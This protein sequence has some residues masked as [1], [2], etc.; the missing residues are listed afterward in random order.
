MKRVFWGFAAVFVAIGLI[1]LMAYR[2]GRLEERK[3]VLQQAPA[4]FN[5]GLVSPS[6][7]SVQ[8][9]ARSSLR[10]NSNSAPQPGTLKKRPWDVQWVA[11]LKQARIGD[12]LRFELV[13]G[14]YALGTIRQLRR[15]GDA[16][17]YVSGEVQ[18]PES[19]RFFFQKQ[20][21]SGVAGAFVGTVEFPASQTAFRIEPSGL[22]G[23]SELVERPLSEVIC[24]ELPRPPATQVQPVKAVQPPFAG[25]HPSGPV[26]AYQN[27]I[28]A[29]ESLHGAKAVLYLDFQGGYTA[30]WGGVTYAK[31]DVSN[32]QIQE[33]F[34]RVA[35]DFM[36][37]DINVTTDLSVYQHAP[38][39]SRQ[40]VIITPTPFTASDVSGIAH[41]GSFNW[42]GDNP[43]WSFNI[44][45]KTCAE[46]C[47]HELGHTLG[48]SHQG[49][50]LNGIHTEYCGG[51]GSGETGWAPIMGLSFSENV[52]Q[53]SQGEY[54]DANNLQDALSIISANNNDVG[55][56]AD[57][58]GDTLATSRYLELFSNYTAGATG[59]IERTGDTDAFQFTT[60]GGAVSLRVDPAVVGPNLAL[61]IALYDPQDSLLVSTNPQNTLWASLNTNLPA[62]TYTFR[63]SGTGRND[64]L[65]NG[66]SAYGSLG[67]YSITGS[68]AN[69]RLP[70]RFTIKEHSPNG[71]IVGLLSV[72]NSGH[73]QLAFAI[74]SGGPGASTL[75]LDNSGSLSV[76]RSDLLDY[77]TLELTSRFV[78]QIEL[79]VQVT[80]LT[81][82]SLNEL[83]RRVVVGITPVQT[84]P[85][86]VEQPTDLAVPTGND[87]QL[88]V[89]AT[90]TAPLDYQWFFEG[91]PIPSAQDQILSFTNINPASS[92]SYFVTVS[93]IAGAVTS[94][95]V[96]LSVIVA[97]PFITSQPVSLASL[98]AGTNALLTVS[99]TGSAPLGYQWFFAGEPLIGAQ[100]KVLSFTNIQPANSGSYFVTVS[101]FAGVVTSVVANLSIIA[102]PPLI[103]SQTGSQT[104]IISSNATFAV[105]ATGEDPLSFQWQ[106][107]GGDLNSATNPV[108]A[109]TNLSFADAGDYRVVISSAAGA[110]TSSFAHLT[111]VGLPPSVVRQ[112][113]GADVYFGKPTHLDVVAGGTSP[114]GYQWRF[115]GKDIPG[116]TNSTLEFI[117]VRQPQVG[118]YSVVISNGFGV[119]SS[120]KARITV[121]QVVAW[122]DPTAQTNVPA[123]LTGI[124]R[125]A[126]GLYHRLALRKDGTVLSWGIAPS[127]GD[128]GQSIVPPGLS[129]IV[130]IAAGA[131]HS[132]ALRADGSVVAWGAGSVNGDGINYGGQAVV[133]AGLRNVIAISAGRQ[134]SVA[135]QADGR[136]VVWGYLP[137]SQTNIPPT[138]TNIVQIAASDYG[139]VALRADG[140]PVAWGSIPN[141][142]RP[143]SNFVAVATS[144]GR[145]LGLT[146]DG[147]VLS[148]SGSLLTGPGDA[149]QIAAP[150]NGLYQGM[151]IRR[152]GTVAIWPNTGNNGFGL[153]NIP[154]GLTNAVGLACSPIGVQVM[155]MAV[156]GD[157]S[158]QVMTQPTDRAANKGGRTQFIVEGAGQAALSYQW[159]RDGQP[160]PGATNSVLILDKLQISDAADYSVSVSNALGSSSSRAAH[161][162]VVAPIS[163]SL[164]TPGL[165]WISNGDASWFGQSETTHDGIDAAQ[166]GRITDNQKTLLQ[167]VVRGPGTL[168]FWWKVS[169]EPWFDYLA[170]SIDGLKQ[171]AIS[172]EVDWQ[173]QIFTVSNGTHVLNWTYSKDGADSG[174]ADSAWVDQV[175]F[176]SGPPII[177]QQPSSQSVAAG[178][179]L[180]LSVLVSGEPPFTYQWVKNGTNISGMISPVLNIRNA[181]EQDSGV[182]AVL[183]SNSV[184]T[185]ASSNAVVSVRVPAR[186]SHPPIGV[187]AKARS[188]LNPEA[189]LKRLWDPAFLAGLKS[190]REN[191]PI[192]FELVDGE[193]ASGTIKHLQR[194]HGET[195]YVSGDLDQPERGR[196]FF[197]K[198]TR[199][200]V[201]GD[202]AGVI[203]LP[204]SQRSYRI[205]PSGPAGAAEL[206]EHALDEVVCYKPAGPKATGAVT[207]RSNSTG[208]PTGNPARP[209]PLN[210]N[211]I[212]SLESLHGATA[213]IYLDF[214][215]GYT[216]NWGGVTYD[217][218]DVTN[219]QITEVFERVAEDF[220]P[221]NIN[222]TTDLNIF[223][224]ALEGSRQRVIITPFS[225]P[226][227]DYAGIGYVGSFNWTGDTPCWCFNVSGKACAETCSHE[228]GHTLGLGHQG[229]NL[230]ELFPGQGT[231]ET[232][233]A[234]I[235]GLSLSNN[236]SQ[237]SKGEFRGANN[238]ED[239][240]AIISSQNNNVAFS[241]DDTGD[242]L[243]G[244]RYLEV[245]SNLTVSAEGV[246]EHTGD[247]DAFR[248]STTGGAFTL[249]ADP[250]SAGANLAVEVGLYD[251]QDQ[252]LA[253]SNPQ[254][255]LWASLSTNLPAGTYT[256]RVT[257]AG[258]NNPLTNGFSNYASLGYYS[259]TGSIAGAHPA[260]RFS[261]EEHSTNGT[262]VGALTINNT[263]QHALSFSLSS[264]DGAFAVDN[265]GMLTVLHSNSLDYETLSRTSRFAPHIEFFVNIADLTDGE[266]NETNRRVVVMVTP[267]AIPPFVIGQPIDLA[268]PA[269]TNALFSVSVGGKTPLDYQWYFDGAPISGATDFSLGLTNIQTPNAG[270]YLVMV[271][272][273]FGAVTSVVAQLSVQ[274]A[275]PF[276]VAQPAAQSVLPQATAGFSVTA[277]GTEPFTYQWLFNGTN[278]LNATN[279][280]LRVTN[281]LSDS[282]GQ[283]TVL[284]SNSAGSTLSDA[285]TLSPLPASPFVVKQPA[286]Q[287]AYIDGKARFQVLANG[288]TP[289]NYQWR[290][291]SADVEGGTNSILELDHVTPSQAGS[292]FVLVSN[293]YG[294]VNSSKA[295]LQIA[296]VA[297][298]GSNIYGQT[299]VPP[300]L[301][302]VVQVACGIAHNLAL[303]S[304]GTILTW[305]KPTAGT[306]PNMDY[307]Q[308]A[309]PPDA[310]NVVGIAAGS[311]HNLVLKGDGTVSA[312]GAGTNLS[313]RGQA[314]VPGGLKNITAVAAGQYH[315]AALSADGHVIVWG[316]T[317]PPPAEAT[318]VIAIASAG[319]N[320]LALRADGVLVSWSDSA[321]FPLVSNIVSISAGFG[322]RLALNTDGTVLSLDGDP[323]PPGLTNVVKIAARWDRCMALLADGSLVTWGGLVPAGSDPGPAGLPWVNTIACGYTHSV[324]VL[325]DGSPDLETQP[326]DRSLYPGDQTVF[327]ADADGRPPLSYQWQLNGVDLPGATNSALLL[328]N[329]QANAGGYYR[330]VVTN[331]LG[332]VVSR[333]AR[334]IMLGSIGPAVNAPDLD[335]ISSLTPWY[336]ESQISH[337]GSVAAQSGAIADSQQSW[338]QTTSTGPGTLNFWWK[339]SSE[340]WF[341]YLTF[342]I[343]GIQQESI[344]GEVDWQQL[345]FP[346]TAG[347]HTLAW[348]Y[349][350]DATDSVGQDAGW[351]DQVAFVPDIPP[352]VFSDPRWLPDG[353][354]TIMAGTSNSAVIPASDLS[355]LAAQTS[356]N[357][358]QW[359]LLPL[360]LTLTNGTIILLDPAASNYPARFYRIIEQ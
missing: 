264:A 269:G 331:S 340:Q 66:F 35:E 189:P 296:Q 347:T 185:V 204:G 195:I 83:G 313:N 137:V 233:W 31:P 336:P 28:I 152:N 337:D 243:A 133:P 304:D 167:T 338:V 205:E 149:V 216:P 79:F 81:D 353:S 2:T 271:S 260:D 109:L 113:A 339:V 38:D 224:H 19:G 355:R 34:A 134:H 298:W 165:T 123:G 122:G 329:L 11:N 41:L 141:L 239:A 198:Q 234:P 323:P 286:N 27:G 186:W 354:L 142:S 288:W 226:V 4:V 76:A 291:A 50:D 51:Q 249:R 227:A 212:V 241:P 314:T 223:Q 341:D 103:I 248:F 102:E 300:E 164:D 230:I 261:I 295:T 40:R 89:S 187:F 169:S 1:G 97:P 180:R 262:T 24:L 219:D 350:K 140:L 309:V 155:A 94:V 55:Y 110:A 192:R 330:V 46:T 147:L 22:E 107:N 157:G 231:G 307:G 176:G 20:S 299:S 228:L 75:A 150:G 96:K 61:Q 311:Y 7:V 182:Y 72:Q 136:V 74:S 257:G 206:V 37:F 254:D 333:S 199:P 263:N 153:G 320:V 318:N 47:S 78:V 302:G 236:V 359:E 36:P 273:L 324:V 290:F 250:A 128:Y 235:M 119:I 179:N 301:S 93:N 292:Y 135:L 191:D 175:E 322:H 106:L 229:Q 208:I 116:E 297:A 203:E 272:N 281:V 156:L 252:P 358:I 214:Q 154:S 114:F 77:Q 213:V 6:P 14:N 232:S 130:D 327:T 95:V 53:W 8:E 85:I 163:D 276:V 143:G 245:Y 131:Y 207:V 65:T 218:P 268:L 267:A 240:L 325:G 196:F 146:R 242:T 215:G 21:R 277:V 280:L 104:G 161:L 305:A 70:D 211:G 25:S 171:A 105:M 183:V 326:T 247:T 343:D 92:G 88:T 312:W 238:K 67:F 48:L 90:G 39:G 246:I 351:L 15:T 121:T 64:P 80:D 342:Y 32:D 352:I 349:S 317:L 255:T 45:G 33:V 332:R 289:L 29:L 59:V 193:F 5:S 282:L 87:A 181:A 9:P 209:R 258:R 173:H 118:E 274:P 210:Q 124:V 348:V 184:G 162:T 73:H 126:C 54:L 166:S 334:L 91:H 127:G 253:I 112:P 200:G 12:P 98:P 86:I 170:F 138:A 108:L 201:A 356:T 221:F 101:N 202:F 43:C 57:D 225:F 284:V 17:V 3:L 287:V 117:G 344:S 30:S 275:A 188:L 266:L 172:G 251:E 303:K 159:Q 68:V 293:S 49:K 71:T 168:G 294:V 222:V 285:A 319:F 270:G 52:S 69:A 125:V 151:A 129:N 194:I 190:A 84:P 310:T 148:S 321:P 132:L 345:S 265:S 256:F 139:V 177:T 217:K 244:S 357:L 145:W 115:N 62:G 278:L 18:Q 279:Q 197:Q 174:G 308:F 259:I 315:S 328:A 44:S 13:A 26:P 306:V 220:M 360:P 23:S 237:W 120:A 60:S 346:L 283:Y 82:G 99:A 58:A 158:A 144:L 63:V 16:V 56:S 335:W 111:C 42:T 316:Q 178:A 160:L 100:D 10:S